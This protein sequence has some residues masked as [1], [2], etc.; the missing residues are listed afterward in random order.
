MTMC[1]SLARS[2]ARYDLHS[3]RMSW[4]ELGV[5]YTSSSCFSIAAIFLLS[6][7]SRRFTRGKCGNSFDSTI[8]ALLCSVCSFASSRN[9]KPCCVRAGQGEY[10]PES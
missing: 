2:A 8:K 1:F 6:T 7:S 4:R 5:L 3:A 9:M 10:R